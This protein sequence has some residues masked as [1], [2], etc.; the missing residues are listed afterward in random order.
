[1][2]GNPSDLSDMDHRLGVPEAMHENARRHGEIV[3]FF[4]KGRREPSDLAKTVLIGVIYFV[5]GKL[6]LKMAFLH[7]SASP[8]WPPT[9]IAIA[10]LLLLG[11]RIWPGIWLG[12][13]LV[14]ITTTGTVA[15]SLAI[16]GGN[17]LEPVIAASLVKWF[18]GGRQA[19][20]R[21]IDLFRFVLLAVALSTT[22]SATIGVTA[23]ALGGFAPWRQYSAIWLTWW[24]GDAVSAKKAS[25]EAKESLEVIDVAQLL[26][27]SVQAPVPVAPP[28]PEA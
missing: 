5:S 17:T 28:E 22:V 19:F 18:A 26:V 2:D 8:V 10:A 11:N 3:S 1:M 4:Q 12:A 20:N 24:L 21:A 7:Q 15:T 14:N 23:L 16:A 25:G 13:F 9:G 27:R 6:G